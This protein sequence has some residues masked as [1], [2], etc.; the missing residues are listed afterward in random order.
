MGEVRQCLV[1]EGKDT[2]LGG[3]RCCAEE[4][5]GPTQ[6]FTGSRLNVEKRF[7]Q[8]GGSRS[9]E[10][11]SYGTQ[12]ADKAVWVGLVAVKQARSNEFWIH[13]EDGLA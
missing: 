11:A 3:G 4:G 6:V 8:G 12:D 2:G 13:S 10:R 7:Q 9:P 1:A 5:Q